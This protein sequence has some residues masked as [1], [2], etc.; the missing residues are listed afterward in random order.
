MRSEHLLILRDDLT[1][2][3]D[4]SSVCA[5][6]AAALF[7]DISASVRRSSQISRRYFVMPPAAHCSTALQFAIYRMLTVFSTRCVHRT[8]C[9]AIAM[10]CI[11]LSVRMSEPG[12]HCDHAVRSSVDIS[13]WLDSPLFRGP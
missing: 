7:A 1:I 8:N 4:L 6:A 12:V 5:L 11:R 2:C 13:L 3:S 10:M 9:R